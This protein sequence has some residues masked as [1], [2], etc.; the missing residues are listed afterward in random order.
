[1]IFNVLKFDLEFIFNFLDIFIIKSYASKSTC[2]FISNL[3]HHV[4]TVDLY[5]QSVKIK[6][7]MILT[8]RL[9][10]GKILLL[11]PVLLKPAPI[12]SLQQEKKMQGWF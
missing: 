1:M 6:P 12:K 10:N 2:W 11:F 4:V 8:S 3:M 9:F 7:L 5:F